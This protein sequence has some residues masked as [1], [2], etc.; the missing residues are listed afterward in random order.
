VADLHGESGAR[1]SDDD[2][3]ELPEVA[4]RRGSSSARKQRQGGGDG[5]R[6]RE[7]GAPQEARMVRE[8]VPADW[9]AGTFCA[10]E[11]PPSAR[12]AGSC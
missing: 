5:E 9:V 10:R 12:A 8:N 7:D 1:Q 6:D 4:R 11:D 3:D 2:L